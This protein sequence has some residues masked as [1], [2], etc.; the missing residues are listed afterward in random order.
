MLCVTGYGLGLTLTSQTTLLK[1][2][3]VQNE[4]MTVILGTT[5]DTLTETMRFMLVSHQCK[6]RQKVEQVQAYFNALELCCFGNGYFRLNF[7]RSYRAV[8]SFESVLSFCPFVLSNTCRSLT[9]AI[10]YT[11]CYRRCQQCPFHSPLTKDRQHGFTVCETC[12]II[13]T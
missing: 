2:D 6:T 4:P 9:H 13:P 10:V 3:R 12:L 5:K 8:Q 11:V 7:G 1:L